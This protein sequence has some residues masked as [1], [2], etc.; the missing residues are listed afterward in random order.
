MWP[1]A[2]V[3]WLPVLPPFPQ[4]TSFWKALLQQYMASS[5]ERQR[6]AFP[7][8]LGKNEVQLAALRNK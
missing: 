6:F 4:H 3:F 5:Q 1:Q 8:T 2:N 7:L